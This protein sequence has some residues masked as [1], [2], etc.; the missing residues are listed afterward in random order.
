[1][2]IVPIIPMNSY[3]PLERKISLLVEL[4][5]L[6]PKSGYKHSVLTALLHFG[7]N[8]QR[9]LKGSHFKEGIPNV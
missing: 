5:T 6:E 9:V 4:R 2:F 8:Q 7:K 1:M 3:A